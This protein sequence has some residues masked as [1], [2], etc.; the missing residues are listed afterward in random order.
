MTKSSSENV[1]FNTSPQLLPAMRAS[2]FPF[3]NAWC[4]V[5]GA[6]HRDEEAGGQPHGGGAEGDGD[7]VVK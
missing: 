1:V 2:L 5:P 3:I 7:V 4:D 6:G